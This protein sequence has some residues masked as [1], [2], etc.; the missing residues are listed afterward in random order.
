MKTFYQFITEKSTFSTKTIR[1]LYDRLNLSV[2]FDEFRMGMGVELE[3]RDVTDGDLETTAKI[4]L[5]HLKEKSDY[6][7]RL[8]KVE[9]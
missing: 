3:H 6:Y 2:D 4:V 7:T 8:K 1:A 9:Q 5:A